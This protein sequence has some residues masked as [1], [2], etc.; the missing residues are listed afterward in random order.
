MSITHLKVSTVPDGAD[1]SVVRP[2][3]WN[4]D[5]VV[6]IVNADVDAAAAIDESKLNLNFATHAAV[7]LGTANGL[8]LSTQA[9]SLALASTSTTGALSDTD[10]DTF[11][12]KQNALSLPLSAANGGT[13]IANTNTLTLPAFNITLGGG[14]AAQTYTLPAAGGTFALLNAANV[15]TGINSFRTDETTGF[16]VATAAAVAI[17]RVNG[18]T[19]QVGIG[20][21]PSARF[22]VHSVSG[23]AASGIRLIMDANSAGAPTS[24]VPIDFTVPTTGLIGQFL[25]TA[26]NYSNASVNLLS[27]SVALV[28]AATSGMLLLGAIGANGYIALN[29]GGVDSAT[30][31]M[32]IIKTGLIGIGLSAPLTLLHLRSNTAATNTVVDVLT[33][34]QTSTGTAAAGLGAGLLFSLETA[35]ASTMQSAGRVYASWIDATNATRKAMLTLSAYDTA[36][37][38]GLQIEASGTVV[39]LGFYATAPVV[40]PTALTTQ[41][42]TITFTAPGTPDYALQDVTNIT[43]YG[44]ADAEEARTFISVVKNLQSRVA[45]LETKLQSLGLLT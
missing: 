28:S 22:D 14:G 31:R 4:A 8:S 3:D 40:K 17:F 42:T 38:I 37:R 2:S 30:E 5:H 15:Y 43:P 16:T 24:Y 21:A 20:A 35:T 44:F 39:K 12:N 34:E 18:L 6:S 32:R 1:T 13:G 29:A 41:L 26:S 23:G 36:E 33:I 7:T 9:L 25:A 10:W 27:N 19:S 11:N 45:E